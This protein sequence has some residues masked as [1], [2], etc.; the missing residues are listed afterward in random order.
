[1]TTGQRNMTDTQPSQSHGRTSEKGTK[2]SR[3][4]LRSI[5]D[6]TGWSAT[7]LA[8][9]MGLD[10]SS[11][12]KVLRSERNMGFDLLAQG[13]HRAGFTI[14][15]ER[16]APFAPSETDELHGLLTELRRPI[17][18]RLIDNGTTWRALS[19]HID[20]LVHSTDR[21][22]QCIAFTQASYGIRDQRWLATLAGLYRYLRWGDGTSRRLMATTF[23][24]TLRRY[25]LASPWSPLP[26]AVIDHERE[27]STRAGASPDA[28]FSKD[29]LVYNV[30]IPAADLP[31][32]FPSDRAAAERRGH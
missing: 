29:F 3:T 1:M 17:E 12:A 26:N 18:Q 28:A 6:D 21:N 30:L 4:I 15:V 25:R 9:Q 31:S 10:K 16:D 19:T 5:M 24:P 7:E 32:S 11:I 27:R 14:R 20:E 13:L 2:P 8:H 23:R 22:D